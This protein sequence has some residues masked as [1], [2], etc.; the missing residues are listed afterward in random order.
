MAQSSNPSSTGQQVVGSGKRPWD[1]T[2]PLPSSL[3]SG[4]KVKAAVADITKLPDAEVK[5]FRKPMPLERDLSDCVSLYVTA[6][7]KD[8]DLAKASGNK[9]PTLDQLL[10]PPKGL[11]IRLK[12][13]VKG[14]LQEVDVIAA[15]GLQRSMRDLYIDFTT[16]AEPGKDGFYWCFLPLLNGA[17][18]PASAVLVECSKNLHKAIPNAKPISVREKLVGEDESN[19]Q[20]GQPAQAQIKK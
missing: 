2:K 15:T 9:V 18:N 8:G 19:L 5:H 7:L 17:A 14:Q 4:E 6:W 11:V 1:L 3:V 16:N 10:S 13:R 12:R 20:L